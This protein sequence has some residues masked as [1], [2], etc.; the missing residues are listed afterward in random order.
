M[1][2]E[3]PA[4][5]DLNVLLQ[6]PEGTG[7]PAPIRPAP[8]AGSEHPAGT[9]RADRPPLDPQLAY[10]AERVDALAHQVE[11]LRR[12]LAVRARPVPLGDAE[13][14]ALADAIVARLQP[15]T[16]PAP[17]GRPPARRPRR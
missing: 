12:R 10:L 8:A 2:G 13:V 9:Q 1:Q 4:S 15:G 3:D 17:G 16:E 6:W 14:A 11:V 7:E 5:D